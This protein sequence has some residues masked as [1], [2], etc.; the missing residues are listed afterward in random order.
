MRAMA[1]KFIPFLT[2]LVF[3]GGTTLE[4]GEPVYGHVSFVDNEATVLRADGTEARAV[5]NM[6]LTTG[7]AVATSAGGR[8]ELQF[9]NGT[10]VRLDTGSR[11][12][13]TTLRAPSLTSSWEIT[14]LELEEGQLYA[15]PQTYSREMF[16]VVTPNATVRL[17]SRAL[18]T[19]RIDGGGTSFFSDAGRFKVLFG[20]D[21]RSL[22]QIKVTPGRPAAIGGDHALRDRVQG[23]G[24][25]FRAWNEYVDRHFKELH[26]G[27][28]KVPP[29]LKFGNTALTYWAEKW[30]SLVGEWIYDDIFGYVWRPA[31]DR[32]VFSDRPFFHADFVRIDGQLFLVP[33]QPWGWVPAHMGTWVW[34]KRG[35]TWIP[36]DWFHPG[37]VDFHGSYVFPTFHFYWNLFY[38]S[39][40]PRPAGEPDWPDR[41]AR[42]PGATDLPSPVMR[43]IKRV[44]KVPDGNESKRLAIGRTVT[45]L[46]GMKPTPVPRLQTPLGDSAA[47]AGTLP[48]QGNNSHRSGE[49]DGRV[50]KRDWNP[51][52]RWAARNGYNI[53][54]SSDRNAVVC[55][56]LKISSRSLKGIGRMIFRAQAE[57]QRSASPAP[58]SGAASGRSSGEAT[59]TATPAQGDPGARQATDDKGR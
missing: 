1:W 56:E 51:D 12:R 18:A 38:K 44:A 42:K 45:P 47:R 48:V 21:A 6:P 40:Y 41:P 29:K 55:P 53:R 2:A 34:L 37:I 46:E 39:W 43:L 54:Y 14:T 7:D 16:Q 59:G 19:I 15:L 49:P 10:V 23:R 3:L 52:S 31:D 50:L 17:K 57:S 28:S 36:G 25:E 26:H 4:A 13:L 33:Q 35:W 9:A 20:A 24:L 30:S 32:F 27:V 5:V 8:C 11:L 22:K 58:T